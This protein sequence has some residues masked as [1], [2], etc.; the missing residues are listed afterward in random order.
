MT[1]RWTNDFQFYASHL[2]IFFNTY[3]IVFFSVKPWILH[4]LFSSQSSWG[5]D[6]SFLPALREFQLNHQNITI[7]K[8]DQTKP[9]AWM[10]DITDLTCLCTT[11]QVENWGLAPNLASTET[12]PTT[13]LQ[14]QLLSWE[15]NILANKAL[16]P[17]KI[18]KL[19][20]WTSIIGHSLD[21]CSVGKSCFFACYALLLLCF[22]ISKNVHHIDI[23][24][25]APP[26]FQWADAHLLFVCVCFWTLELFIG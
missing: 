1:D 20:H 2:V 6:P 26:L 23:W 24:S 5:K 3:T 22:P 15:Y 21:I 12:N 17:D 16:Y 25:S 4:I 9:G 14:L 13:L 10:S 18:Y 11:H 19:G 7:Q 8:T